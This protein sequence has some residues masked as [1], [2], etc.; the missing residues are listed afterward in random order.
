MVCYDLEFP[1]WVRAAALRGAE[2]LCVPTNW[3]REPRPDG[4]RP[5]EVLRA[6]VAASTNRM[7]VAACD[8]CGDER[9]VELGRRLR[10]RRARRLAARRAARRRRRRRCCV[11]DVDL[12][13]ARDKALGPRNDVLGR[14]PPG[15]V[16]RAAVVA[17]GSGAPDD[18]RTVLAHAA[19]ADR[20]PA[21][22]CSAASRPRSARPAARSATSSWSS[23]TGT[24]R[25][26]T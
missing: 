16:R 12:A 7:A 18:L 26:A 14:P 4:E 5:M 1:E 8:R 15:A 22:A 20:P 25:C 24:T 2:L 21:R 6:M 3:P 17:S 11:A 19:R 9:G 23:T 10:D 13:A